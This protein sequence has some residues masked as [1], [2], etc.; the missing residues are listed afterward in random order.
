MSGRVSQLSSAKII[1]PQEDDAAESHKALNSP[2]RSRQAGDAQLEHSMKP[3]HLNGRVE[4]FQIHNGRVALSIESH[5]SMVRLLSALG[6]SL[7]SSW[8]A[9]LQNHPFA[10]MYTSVTFPSRKMSPRPEDLL[11][12]NTKRRLKLIVPLASFQIQS[13]SIP[14]SLTFY[15]IAPCRSRIF[16]LCADGN[17]D[18]VKSWLTK[19]RM[20]PFVVNKHGENLLHVRALSP[21]TLTNFNDLG[22][23]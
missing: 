8:R 16:S 4:L 13:S 20:S 6:V 17:I 14:W 23:C 15:P 5:T 19:S 22:G 18:A 7:P 9:V 11:Y 2:K 21:R 1:P 12:S 3:L 10:L